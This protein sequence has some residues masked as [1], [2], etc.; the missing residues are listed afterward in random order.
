MTRRLCVTTLECPWQFS[1]KALLWWT[2]LVAVFVIFVETVPP[3]TPL[4]GPLF[5]LGQGKGFRISARILAFVV[6]PFI[7]AFPAR[8]SKL[9]AAVSA[10]GIVFW[11]GFGYFIRTSVDW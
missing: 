1:V 4:S 2:S 11:F 9:T 10:G 7:V 3:W 5:L 8:P 6:M